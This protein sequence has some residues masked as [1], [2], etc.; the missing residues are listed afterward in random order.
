MSVWKS[1]KHAVALAAWVASMGQASAATY[2]LALTGSLANGQFVDS[3]GPDFD[4]GTLSLALTGLSAANAFTVSQGDSIHATISLRQ[5]VP[6]PATETYTGLGLFLFGSNFPS[7]SLTATTATTISLFNQDRL[8]IT[9]G[10]NCM[11]RSRLLACYFVYPPNN[12]AL[13]FDSAT[14]NFTI[15]TLAQPVQLNAASIVAVLVSP[16]LA[17]P[18]PEVAM[19]G[20][21]GAGV[22]GF[23]ARRRKAQ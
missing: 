19:L 20:L 16:A 3:P 17:V 22:A 21:A 12:R 10:S 4:V 15:A 5:S 11:D 7:D 6:L 18:E 8:V 13:T 9:G 1:M 2:E 14:V 23:A